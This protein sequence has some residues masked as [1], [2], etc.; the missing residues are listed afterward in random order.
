MGASLMLAETQSLRPNLF[1]A[2]GL[3]PEVVLVELVLV[4]PVVAL[5]DN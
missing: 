2:V 4:L 1:R 3:D 5:D